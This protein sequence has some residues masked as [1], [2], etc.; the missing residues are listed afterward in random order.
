MGN[1]HVSGLGDII[2]DP[3]ILCWHS[4]NLHVTTGVDIYIP[5]GDYDT[6]RL[7]NLGCNVFVYEPIVAVTYMTPMQ[8]VTVSAKF[9][10]DFPD[11][12]NHATHPAT[13][14]PGDLQY[15][16]EFHVDYSVDYAV[17]ENLKVGL[18]GY[19]LKQTTNDEFEGSDIHGQ[20]G[21]VWA[22]GPG[23]EYAKG[24]FIVS[25]RALF[26]IDA[27]NRPEGIANWLRAVWVF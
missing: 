1:C 4:E 25:Y 6:G 12:N 16:Q 18:G 22:A 26:E 24:R 19:F 21:R 8:G 20:T 2:I 15:G 23:F 10:Y 11:R 14:V 9:M 7:A 27:R 13:G 3:F 5:T 17:N